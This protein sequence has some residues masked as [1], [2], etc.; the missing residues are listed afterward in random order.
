MWEPS[1]LAM[2]VAHPAVMGQTDRFREQARSHTRS[3]QYTESVLTEDPLWEPSL[4]A[5]ASTHPALM[6][7][8]DRYREQARSHRVR[9]H[10]YIPLRRSARATR[11]TS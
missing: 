2:A 11:C 8:T 6:G 5:M 7:Q 4:L 10:D 9:R 3:R 1:L